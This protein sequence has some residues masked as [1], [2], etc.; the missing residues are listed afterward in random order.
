MAPQDHLSDRDL[1]AAA[2]A[3]RSSVADAFGI[4]ATKQR[5]AEF[6]NL[7][8]EFLCWLTECFKRSSA[9][10]IGHGRTGIM[11]KDPI[12]FLIFRVWYL[13]LFVCVQG[14]RIATQDASFCFGGSACARV[15]A[16]RSILKSRWL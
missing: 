14:S 2:E 3:T 8:C 10:P 7:D 9:S 1:G 16:Q 15:S 4:P 11:A 6:A 5:L 13:V 12:R